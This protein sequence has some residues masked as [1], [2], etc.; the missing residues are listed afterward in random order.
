M[1]SGERAAYDTST[2]TIDIRALGKT[3]GK[4][5]P[6]PRRVAQKEQDERKWTGCLG[7]I[8]L[9]ALVAGAAWVFW[10]MF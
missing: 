9:I 7:G 3:A 10:R 2:K 6:L 4:A 5:K 8:S 1:D